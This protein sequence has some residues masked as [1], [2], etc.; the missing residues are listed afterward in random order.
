MIR[1][2]TRGH[3]ARRARPSSGRSGPVGGCRTCLSPP[4]NGRPVSPGP[5]ARSARRRGLLRDAVGRP[6]AAAPP[7]VLTAQLARHLDAGPDAVVAR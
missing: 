3:I 7:E 6:P 4:S 5:C 2:L 1:Q